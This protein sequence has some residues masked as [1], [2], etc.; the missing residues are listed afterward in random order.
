MWTIHQSHDPTGMEFRGISAWV[1]EDVY[2]Q[3][4]LW[5]VSTNGDKESYQSDWATPS[6]G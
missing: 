4:S 5:S 2:R 6:N 3:I 1:H